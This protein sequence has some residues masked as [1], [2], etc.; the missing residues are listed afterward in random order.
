MPIDATWP[1]WSA[2]ALAVYCVVAYRLKVGAQPLR[3]MM[4]EEGEALLASNKL[5]EAG[6]IFVSGLLSTAFNYF[7]PLLIM[8]TVIPFDAIKDVFFNKNRFDADSAFGI[9]DL[10][11]KKSFDRVN[12]LHTRITFANHPFMTGLVFAWIVFWILNC[13]VVKAIIKG[14]IP[15]IDSHQFVFVT[16][17]KAASLSRR[18]GRH[19]STACPT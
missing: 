13:V 12:D 1:F 5:N 18:I 15:D 16:A 17:G 6:K 3:L 8:L 9:R 11:T 4:A 10:E 14:V 19:N 2:V 7:T